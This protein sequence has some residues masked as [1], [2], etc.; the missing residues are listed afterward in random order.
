MA[1]GDNTLTAVSVGR[2]S[3]IVVHSKYFT[4]DTDEND[5]RIIKFEKMC[6]ERKSDGSIVVVDEDG[7]APTDTEQD[8]ETQSLLVTSKRDPHIVS[9][10]GVPTHRYHQSMFQF[11]RGVSDYEVAVTGRA[12]D[13]IV[14]MSRASQRIGDFEAKE[15]LRKILAQGKVFSRM[16]PKQ[17]AMLIE[18]LQHESGEL[19]GM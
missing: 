10:S 8:P 16:S 5:R 7:D 15:V 17:K 19:I 6:K 12:F 18:E 13:L 4:I 3:G 9:M 14:Q 1:T 11:M 2:K